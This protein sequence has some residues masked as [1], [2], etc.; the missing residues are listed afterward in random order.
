MAKEGTAIS[1]FVGRRRLAAE[2]LQLREERSYTS[3]E[4][5]TVIV[6]RH[7]GQPRQRVDHDRPLK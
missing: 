3:A 5:S 1:P 6:T 4:L 7:D 2:V